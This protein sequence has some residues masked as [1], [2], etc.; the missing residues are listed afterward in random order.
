[1]RGALAWLAVGAILV[2]AGCGGAP[3]PAV[4][5]S[6]AR[7]APPLVEVGAT[8]LHQVALDLPD[9]S[10][11]M[12]GRLSF[13]AAGAL[14]L[15]AQAHFGLD[16]FHVRCAGGA[17]CVVDQLAEPLR[18]KFPADGLA[19]EIGRIY[20]GGCGLPQAPTSSCEVS[21][22][23]L[24]ERRDERGALLERVYT[25]PDGRRTEIVYEEY[26]AWGAS[27]QPRRIKLV[28]GAFKV[29]IVLTDFTP[30]G[31]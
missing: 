4:D 2:L 29:E 31:G 7:W 20:L 15:T 30:A 9:R 24:A 8:L 21:G 10:E 27:W 19:R 25:E 3:K 6:Q 18:G 12:L 13:P 11:V 14:D 26:S 5:A 22:A 16:L 1:M 17:I 28:S 23:R